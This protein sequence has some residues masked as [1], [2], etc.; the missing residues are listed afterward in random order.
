MIKHI[1]VRH[2]PRYKAH[3]PP[4]IIPP[5]QSPQAQGVIPFLGKVAYAEMLKTLKLAKG[6][7]CFFKTANW[8]LDMED[9]VYKVEDIN[10]IFWMDPGNNLT[11]QSPAPYIVVNKRGQRVRAEEG[12]LVRY[13][14]VG[15]AW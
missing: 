1:I 6:D 9:S 11:A 13:K 12:N 3:S 5:S 15:E 10:E 7:Y 8:P 2:K 4:V 14:F